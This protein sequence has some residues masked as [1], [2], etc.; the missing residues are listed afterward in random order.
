MKTLILVFLTVFLSSCASFTSG[1]NSEQRYFAAKQ[2]LETVLT[3]T[4]L[5]IKDCN[6]Q[7]KDNACHGLV[8][9]IGA[10]KPKIHTAFSTA[11][12]FR[13]QSKESELIAATSVVVQLTDE[14]SKYLLELQNE[15][16][17]GR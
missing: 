10:L 5:Y 8:K 7:P 16:N 6:T 17:N 3:G 13:K 2:D 12:L 14:L 1:L 4:V 9:T 11:E 15:V